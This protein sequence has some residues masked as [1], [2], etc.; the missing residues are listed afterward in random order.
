MLLPISFDLYRSSREHQGAP[1]RV[2]FFTVCISVWYLLIRLAR[3]LQ[4]KITASRARNPPSLSREGKGLD[5][6]SRPQTE[7][8]LCR[9]RRGGACSSRF[10][11]SVPF[12]TAAASH[13]P[14]GLCVDGLS[15]YIRGRPK[16]APTGLFLYGLYICMVS[17]HPTFALA[18]GVF[19]YRGKARG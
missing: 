7:I 12:A 11:R 18:N 17:T 2:C 6:P 16:V 14:T 10:V 3:F 9:T 5:R 8:Q 19:H 1:L 13:R 4:A 15:V